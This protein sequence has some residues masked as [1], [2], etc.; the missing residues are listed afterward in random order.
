VLAG[1]EPTGIDSASSQAILQV[2][3]SCPEDEE[4][5][6]FRAFLAATTAAHGNAEA[7]SMGQDLGL[8][9]QAQER[10]GKPI[11]TQQLKLMLGDAQRLF[12]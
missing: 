8:G 11:S 3:A 4:D 9:Q 10:A 12:A 5:T 1:C 7:K 6:L 2:I